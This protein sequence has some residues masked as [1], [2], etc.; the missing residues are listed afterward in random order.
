[1]I[2]YIILSFVNLST[3]FLLLFLFCSCKVAGDADRE[4][5]QLYKEY[6]K[7]KNNEDF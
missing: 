5:E 1:M 7:R 3:M 2:K 4:E 6:I